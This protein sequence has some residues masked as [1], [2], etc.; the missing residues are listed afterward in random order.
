MF[1]TIDEC[2]TY[3]ENQIPQKIDLSLT[4]ITKA[5]QI[6]GNPQNTY[7]TIHITGTNGKGSTSS[8]V[9][10]LLASQGLSVG[11]FTSPHL[12]KYNE[13]IRINNTFISDEDFIRLIT[14]LVK[15][16]FPHVQLTIFECITLIGF[17]YFADKKVDVAVIEVGLGGR[18]DA[19]NIIT[20]R[21]ACITN[22]SVDHVHFLSDNVEKIAYEKAGIFKAESINLHTIDTIALHTV[23]NQEQTAKYI[24]PFIT[25][26][27]NSDGFQ[28]QINEPAFTYNGP[29]PMYGIHQIRNLEAALK[30]VLN[31][32]LL[33]KQ[34][35]NAKVLGEQIQT[36]TW[37]GRMEQVA[38]GIY[39][40]GAH[41]SAGIQSLTQ[42][43]KT[44]FKQQNINIIFS[45]M[46]DKD[47]ESMLYELLLCPNISHIYFLPLPIE[48]ALKHLPPNFVSTSKISEVDFKHFPITNTTNEITIFAG[49]FY[50]YELIMN[51]LQ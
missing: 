18:F 48:R 17:Q 10:Q 44:H 47:Y 16:V 40:D 46:K 49:T 22:I 27:P 39:F 34:G 9:T 8:F 26:T 29:F 2:I 32:L 11:L 3:I 6:L 20:P 25:F 4:R 42:T 33:E 51:L 15:N 23:I 45:V 50:G 12:I 28:I 13:R 19:T 30:I 5:A 43:I 38:P 41:N 21:V 24:E 7:Q 36:L 14:V 37:K 35:F 1:K 31:Y